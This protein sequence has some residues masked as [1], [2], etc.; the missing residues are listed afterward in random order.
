MDTGLRADLHSIKAPNASPRYG[1]IV[2]PARARPYSRPMRT[3]DGSDPPHAP[4]KA[5]RLKEDSPIPAG[6]ASSLLDM[7]EELQLHKRWYPIQVKQKDKVGRPD[8]D[9]FETAMRRSQR[10]KGS[11]VAFDY[12]EDALREIDRFFKADHAVIIPLT[13]QEI[14]DEQIARKLA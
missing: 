11:F 14:L 12:A 13:V 9:S 4:G 3:K 8:I 1:C 6:H 7:H 2:D 5:A 10:E